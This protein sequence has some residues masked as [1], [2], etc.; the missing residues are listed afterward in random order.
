V[1]NLIANNINYVLVTKESL[2][3]WPPQQHI[4][5]TSGRAQPVY[6]DGYS[7]IWKMVNVP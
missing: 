1:T 5:A 6:D 2:D 4:L 7:T 3:R